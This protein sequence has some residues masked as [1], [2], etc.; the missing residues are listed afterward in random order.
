MP[1]NVKKNDSQFSEHYL[2]TRT[3]E[4]NYDL[5]ENKMES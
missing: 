1:E 2:Y 4:E 5:K 3:S